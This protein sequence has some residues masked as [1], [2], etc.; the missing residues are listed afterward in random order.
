MAFGPEEVAL[1]DA[2]TSQILE[3]NEFL[4]AFQDLNLEQSGV[5]RVTTERGLDKT[6][7]ELNTIIQ[8][9]RVNR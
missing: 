9:G 1:N 6:P 4:T 8:S 3:L 2:I 5:E 7:S